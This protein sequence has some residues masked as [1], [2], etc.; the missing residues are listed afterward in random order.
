MNDT[1]WIV[2]FFVVVFLLALLFWLTPILDPFRSQRTIRRHSS[3]FFEA[4][5][6]LKDP[7]MRRGVF[8]VYAFGRKLEDAAHKRQDRELLETIEADFLKA[9]EG[10]RVG[11][12]LFAELMWTAETFYPEDYDYKPFFDMF[13]G[14]KIDLT[15]P[16][17][18]T[19]KQLLDY[20]LLVAGTAGRMINPILAKEETPGRRKF[21]DDLGI[22][23]QLTTILK[24]L[25]TDPVRFRDYLP[26]EMTD[27]STIDWAVVEKGEASEAFQ[28]IVDEISEMAESRYRSAQSAIVEFPVEVRDSLDLSI[29]VYRAI[30]SKVR[31]ADYVP[32]ARRR[33]LSRRNKRKVVLDWLKQRRDGGH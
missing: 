27:K 22:A 15:Q 18:K 10:Q 28:K 16:R 21:A 11:H 5:S 30:L 1:W 13:V 32:S 6:S 14:R 33:V 7:R 29:S 3:S 2:A 9:I 26:D 23:M 17:F 12:W 25:K 8:A 19:N 4:F 31:Q 20:C 24:D